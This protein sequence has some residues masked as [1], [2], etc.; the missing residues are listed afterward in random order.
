MVSKLFL[1][2]FLFCTNTIYCYTLRTAVYKASDTNRFDPL[3]GANLS[4]AMISS[5][6][7]STLFSE[8][9]T[10]NGKI[11]TDGL[12][13]DYKWNDSALTIHL[14][15]N[16]VLSNGEKLSPNDIIFSLKRSFIKS[17]DFLPKLLNKLLCTN[18]LI[19]KITDP[20]KGLSSG[21]NNVTMKFSQYLPGVPLLLKNYA[22]SIVPETAVDKK[23][24]EIVR[25]DITTGPYYY[26]GQDKE[27]HLIL[28]SNQKHWQIAKASP[29]VVNIL[30]DDYLQKDGEGI[31]ISFINFI[32]GKIDFLPF[33][34]IWYDTSFFKRAV[35]KIPSH[36]F[37]A[38]NTT[39]TGST[40]TYKGMSE[41]SI[42][43]RR[44]ISYDI[45]TA[46]QKYLNKKRKNK[47]RIYPG[48]FIPSGIFGSLSSR[49]LKVIE[50]Y[51]NKAHDEYKGRKIILGSNPVIASY[52]RRV[53]KHLDYLKI[54]DV[55]K[56]GRYKLIKKKDYK[57]E[58]FPDLI[59]LGVSSE[60]EE[61]LA[62]CSYYFD[63]GIFKSIEDKPVENVIIDY[64]AMNYQNRLQY[65]KKV[66]LANLYHNPGVIPFWV[67]VNS[68]IVREGLSIP[69]SKSSIKSPFY[70][71][72]QQVK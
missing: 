60:P 6:L 46:I 40:F 28:K 26:A 25:H 32:E 67:G 38:N 7:Y 59:E 36:S 20:C 57:D 34:N 18:K 5:S 17:E 68:M 69:L 61:N 10:A 23:N 13:K 24:L 44:R 30:P 48:Q 54:V 49:E 52:L 29:T 47:F 27:G 71:V 37:T 41:L 33:S 45:Q 9:V 39:I 1:L 51:W 42:E 21:P 43:Q 12:V 31:P 14:N 8:T 72:R 63:K 22:F 50:K 64:L 3:N 70:A 2:F 16:I 4:N 15:D 35:K 53:L 55:D 58:T 66:H 56:D 11:V 65:L 19:E 62:S